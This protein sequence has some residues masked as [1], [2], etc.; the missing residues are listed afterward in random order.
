MIVKVFE[1]EEF[2]GRAAA[3]AII[4][5][6]SAKPNS[7][8]GLPTGSTPV[9]TYRA[10][11]AACAEG[12]V[13]FKDVKTFNLD[14]YVGLN[15]AHEQSY[16]YF[17]NDNLFNHVDI[18]I[19]NTNLPCDGSDLDEATAAKYD[20]KIIAA[21]GIDFQL[22][23][24]GGNGHIGFNEPGDAFVRG[25]HCV[26][27]TESTIQA[28]SRLFD[29]IDDVP[30]QAFTMGIGTIMSA[31]TVLVMANGEVKAQAVH[32]MIYGPITP[33]CQASILQLH[34]NVVVVA[35]EAALSLCPEA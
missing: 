15:P 6:I 16:R 3:D 2:A 7:V 4:A 5:Q 30:R 33:S 27:L 29:S 20:E 25:T 22:L 8:L 17:M 1:N 24:I 18:D 11:S 34:P 14:E 28:N 13:S 35:D 32:D 19:A 10:L 9:P 23:G 21:G 12:R 26:D 31:K